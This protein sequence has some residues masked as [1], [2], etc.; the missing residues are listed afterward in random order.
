MNAQYNAELIDDMKRACRQLTDEDNNDL[1]IKVAKGDEAARREMIVNNMPLVVDKVR[2]YVNHYPHARHLFSDLTSAGFIGLINAVSYIADRGLQDYSNVTG[3]L[4]VAVGRELGRLLDTENLIY[5]RG[6]TRQVAK[7]QGRIIEPPKAVALPADY[8]VTYN[9]FGEV[10]LRDVF[11]ACCESDAERECLRLRE[12]GYTFQEI[13]A[14]L[15]LPQTTTYVMFRQ[16]K[17]RILAH[18]ADE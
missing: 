7:A 13:A 12:A 5:V 2:L 1:A 8:E 3:Y 15:S 16:L 9:P 17:A 6:N 14:V 18:L 10:D 4:S 11:D